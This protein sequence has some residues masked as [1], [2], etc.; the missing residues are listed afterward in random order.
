VAHEAWFTLDRPVHQDIHC[1][2][3][4]A[5]RVAVAAGAARLL[6][7]HLPP[8]RGRVEALRAEAANLLPDTELA[9]DNWSVALGR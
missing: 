3:L 2:A 4:G 1:S 6:L 9:V 7:I 5:A 8:F